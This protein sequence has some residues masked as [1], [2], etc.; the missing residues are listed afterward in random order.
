M[1]GAARLLPAA[2][3]RGS[4]TSRSSSS[5]SPRACCAERS[6]CCAEPET[7]PHRAASC[8]V[9]NLSLAEDDGSRA[10]RRGQ[11]QRCALDEHVAVIGQAAAAR[12][13]WRC[14]SRGWCGR[15]AAASRSAATTS[16]TLPRRRRRPA[17]RLCRRDA[18]SVPGT[19]R[20][21]LFYGLRH[22]PVRA[23]GSTRTRR[24]R[25]TRAAAREARALRQHR[26]L[27]IDADWIDYDAAG[28]D[29][30]QDVTDRRIEM[31]R[32]V[33]FEDDVYQSRPARP[34]RPEAAPGTGRRA[35]SRRAGAS[36]A[37]GRPTLAAPGR[38]LRP[39]SATTRNATVAE[40]LLFGT[41]IGP[42]FDFDSAGRQPYVRQVLDKVGLTSR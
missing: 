8:R 23:G 32:G 40:N 29:G 6:C 28:A 42:A 26:L 35:C 16:P 39:P 20:D 7:P 31:L 21:N 1:E 22:R 2:G 9:G 18:V 37:A 12:T 33:D 17:H 10:R 19:L 30:P 4:S 15:P 34:R 5:S 38:A 11:L 24:Q 25:S 27:D 3:R 41:P 14:C 36:A 13:S